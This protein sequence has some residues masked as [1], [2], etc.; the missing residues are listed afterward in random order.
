MTPYAA[1]LRVYEPLSAFAGTEREHWSGYAAGG[2]A[3]DRTAGVAQEYQAGRLALLSAPPIPKIG[4]EAFVLRID[5]GVYV[6]PWR[7]RERA[8]S[9]L[10]DFGEDLPDSVTAAF[11]PPRA[12]GA[13]GAAAPVEQ[14]RD[15]WTA[16]RVCSPHIETATWQVPLRW[17][18]LV[19]PDE[20]RLVTGRRVDVPAGGRGTPPRLTRTL[21]YLTPMSRARRRLAR[22]LSV[23]RRTVEDGPVIA[24]VEDLGR[25]LEEFHPHS[26]VELDYAGLVQ[27]LD[28]RALR[29]DSSVSDVAT[30]LAALGRRDLRAAA[31]AYER[32]TER[33]REVAAY[34]GAN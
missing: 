8:W 10:A 6:C 30:A 2:S 27:L 4:E 13:G 21:L 28:D 9:A 5:G 33:W 34:E 25:W 12:G 3:P 31:A 29:E 7:T 20:R 26:M 22:A 32:V 16:H 17:F 19:Q 24:G 18:L 14:D 15:E 1:Y 11:F 23:L